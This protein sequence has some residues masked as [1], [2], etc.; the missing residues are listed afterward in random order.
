LSHLIVRPIRAAQGAKDAAGRKADASST[1]ATLAG[2][3][4]GGAARTYSGP[5]P[6]W[7]RPISCPAQRR[8]RAAELDTYKA[9]S[10][11]VHRNK[12]KQTRLTNQVLESLLTRREMSH[13][14][15]IRPRNHVS[16]LI[17]ARRRSPNRPP[18]TP[19]RL[20]RCT[21]PGVRCANS[22]F[23][24]RIVSRRS[25]RSS[26]TDRRRGSPS[27]AAAVIA[28]TGGTPSGIS[29]QGRP[30]GNCDRHNRS[31]SIA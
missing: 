7:R 18:A 15:L 4:L 11:T 1:T 27:R 28:T 12:R 14:R 3:G 24:S 23:R 2:Q 16:N 31:A 6:L 9:T 25:R 19:P 8:S 29:Y 21:K 20:L 17:R 22:T 5:Q 30:T 13:Q 10:R 26:T